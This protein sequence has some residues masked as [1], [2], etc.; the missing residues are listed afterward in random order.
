MINSVGRAL[1]C[2]AGSRR[3]IFRERVE[4]RSARSRDQLSVPREREERGVA[5]SI[6]GDRVGERSKKK[7]VQFPGPSRREEKEFAGLV[8]GIE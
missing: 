2:R 1:V 8:S 4:S 5:G 7:L 6:S 3:F